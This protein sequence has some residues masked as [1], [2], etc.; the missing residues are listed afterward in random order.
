VIKVDSLEQQARLGE[1]TRK[2][3]WAMAYKYPPEE[4]TTTLLDVEFQIGRTGAV[5]PVA[6]LEPVFVGGVT[7]SNATL[8]NFDEVNRLDLHLG[9]TVMVRRAGDVIPQ[10]TAVIA[11]KRGKNATAVNLPE[12]CP[13][14]G[15]AIVRIDDEAVARC[16]GGIKRC[17]AQRKESLR[18]FASRLA[19]DIDG[20]G[21]KLVEQ[22]VEAKLV[23]EPADLFELTESALAELPRM[24]PKSARNLCQALDRSKATSFPR[25]IYALG[26]REVGEATAINLA[27]HFGNLEALGSAKA[28][29]LEAVNDVGPI[30]AHHVESFFSDPGSRAVV[31]HLVEAGVHWPEVTPVAASAPALPLTGQ[32]WVLTGSLEEMTRETAKERLLELGAKVAA[33]VS[34]KTTQVVA[35]PGAGS[36]LEKARSLEVPVMDETQF[37]E[38]LDELAGR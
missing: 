25:F 23:V 12:S 3:R 30:V 14:C 35:G 26:I 31:E 1:V 4:A 17:P 19:L 10:V 6:R 13:E 33:S 38:R 9:D 5:T 11:G 34:K 2:P 36:K 18:H 15:S 32:T 27:A 20:L 21:D 8:H 16:S 7:V 22:L 29:D 37:L 28:E 24:G